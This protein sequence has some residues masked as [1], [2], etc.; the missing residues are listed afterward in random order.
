MY[1]IIIYE[2]FLLRGGGLLPKYQPKITPENTVRISE[3]PDSVK[4]VS[5]WLSLSQLEEID[6]L[7]YLSHKIIYIVED[8][9]TSGCL[10]PLRDNKKRFKVIVTLGK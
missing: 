8:Y 5:V 7:F 2:I 4:S 10:H 3:I 1:V 9:S 6:T